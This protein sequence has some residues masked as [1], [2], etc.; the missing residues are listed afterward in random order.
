MR[1]I[2]V[3]FS[4]TKG[5]QIL[6][7]LITQLSLLSLYYFFVCFKASPQESALEHPEPVTGNLHQ[8]VK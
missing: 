8:N 3:Y 5:V 1:D 4:P 2:Y 6:K 7:L